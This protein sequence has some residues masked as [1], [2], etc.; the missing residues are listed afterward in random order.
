ML[1]SFRSLCSWESKEEKEKNIGKKG[2]IKEG[3]EKNIVKK[4]GDKKGRKE[5]YHEKVEEIKNEEKRI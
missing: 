5:E 2:K 3:K 4:R 1:F